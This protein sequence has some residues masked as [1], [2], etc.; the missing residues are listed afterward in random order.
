MEKSGYINVD[1]L[2]AQTTLE[3]AARLCGAHLDIKGS[4]PEVRIDCPFACPDDHAGRNEVAINV[5]NPQKVFLCHA[6]SCK[7][8]GNLL[9]LMHGWLNG[10]KPT[11][12]KLKGEEFQRVRNVLTRQRT[13][14][15]VHT[16]TRPSPAASESPAPEPAQNVPLIHSQDQK[17]RALHNID[18]KLIVDV[19][20]MSPAAA[21]YVRKHPCLTPE[22]MKKWRCGY[23]PMDG[24]RD[25][26]GWSL[27]GSIVYPIFSV[28]S[29]V[30]AWVRRDPHYEDKEIAFNRLPIEERY[31]KDAPEKYHF[32]KDFQRGIELFGQQASRLQEPGYREFIARYG[33]IVVEG[34]NDVIGLDNLEIPALGIMSNRITAAKPTEG[35][36]EAQLEKI[37]RWARQLAHGRVTLMFDCDDAGD[38]G[39]KEALWL[40]TQRGLA[41]QLAWTRAMHSGRFKERQPESV[42]HNEWMAAILQ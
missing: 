25:K 18:E 17:V 31:G 11:G 21:A 29:H 2:Q 27:R 1:E 24:G 37:S 10:S 19:A 26:R 9:T 34:F 12:G 7:F 15:P 30:L 3:D 20:Q 23:M 8:R 4:G 22:S 6:Y 36:S 40:L 28:D 16:E 41:V 39:A 14:P 13:A 42:T 33:L 35:I 5:D 32:P 38:E